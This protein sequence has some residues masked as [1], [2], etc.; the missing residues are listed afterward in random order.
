[1]STATRRVCSNQTSDSRALRRRPPSNAAPTNAD[2]VKRAPLATVSGQLVVAV[3]L[4][5]GGNR[6]AGRA[7]GRRERTIGEVVW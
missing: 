3:D 6:V 5:A 7:Q 2:S 4:Q 1:M